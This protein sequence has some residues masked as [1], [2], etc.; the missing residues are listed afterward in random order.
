MNPGD[1]GRARDIGLERERAARAEAASLQFV[2]IVLTI[3]LAI[4]SIK[5]MNHLS[6]LIKNC[7]VYRRYDLFDEV[8]NRTDFIIG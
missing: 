4:F 8:R 5:Y 2:L 7:N 3:L 1:E 6:T